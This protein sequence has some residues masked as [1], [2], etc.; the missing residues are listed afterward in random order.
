MAAITVGELRQMISEIDDDMLLV[1]GTNYHG[2]DV[3]GFELEQNAIVFLSNE[4]QEYLENN[5]FS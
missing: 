2:F 1:L 4:L 3:S 5:D